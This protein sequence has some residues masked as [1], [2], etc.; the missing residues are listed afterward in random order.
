MNCLFL[1]CNSL[2]CLEFSYSRSP[3][4]VMVILIN[5]AATD[6][7]F[8]DSGPRLHHNFVCG[9]YYY[10]YQLD[11]AWIRKMTFLFAVSSNWNWSK[12][13]NALITRTDLLQVLFFYQLNSISLLHTCYRIRIF[14]VFLIFTLVGVSFLLLFWKINYEIYFHTDI[15]ISQYN[16]NFT[17]LL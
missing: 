12:K 6:L 4:L 9:T 5:P 16:I 17:N 14:I 11:L 3:Y 13:L 1:S 7:G 8:D 2:W 10:P 15:N